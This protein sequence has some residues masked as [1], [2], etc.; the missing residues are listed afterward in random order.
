MSPKG[1]CKS[2]GSHKDDSAQ[3]AP[4]DLIICCEPIVSNLIYRI[5]QFYRNAIR[6]VSSKNLPYCKNTRKKTF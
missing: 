6:T 5:L 4:E 2:H 3:K 1:F